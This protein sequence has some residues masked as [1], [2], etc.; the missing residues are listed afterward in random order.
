EDL[1][2]RNDFLE[3][4]LSEVTGGIGQIRTYQ[5][6]GNR[7]SQQIAYRFPRERTI[8]V[9]EGEEAETYK[10][11]YSE[12]LMRSARVLS[13]GP[14]VGEIETSGVIVDQ[15]QKKR[16]ADY[17]QVTR[18]VRGRPFVEVDLELDLDTVPDGDPW[19]NYYAA[20]FAWKYETVA[21][22]GSLHHGAHPINTDRIEA[23]QFIEL[24]DEGSRTTILP[25][26]LP[27][28]RKTGPRM[29]DTLLVVAGETRRRFRFAIAVDQPYPIQS[30][31][32]VAAPSLAIP[33]AGSPPGG[34]TTGWLFHL[35]A[36][37]VQLARLLPLFP[38]ETASGVG[39][40]APREREAPAE[41][42]SLSAAQSES[43][44][45]EPRP[46]SSP[47]RQ[48]CIVRLVETEGRRKTAWLR[49]FRTPTAARQVDFHGQTINKLALEGD[50][51]RV[52][53]RPYEVC[54]VEVLW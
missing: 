42:L 24:A 20:R 54:D 7:I 51:V 30:A 26:G 13:A 31:L 48:G 36:G 39:E 43:A 18:V 46:P 34:A 25:C 2:L 21:L 41:P 22:S 49:C 40:G 23:P 53:V 17:R 28:H 37:N 10:S 44:R 1:L 32:D 29:L 12:M 50:G 33:T 3:V 19:T 8:T 38:C 5:R 16:L 9:G 15:H 14:A 47:P 11:Y 45:Q 4:A 35:S 6:G 27:Y 52:D